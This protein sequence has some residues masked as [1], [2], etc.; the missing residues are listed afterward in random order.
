M[1]R[2]LPVLI[3]IV[4]SVMPLGG[5]SLAQDSDES[6]TALLV[7]ASDENGFEQVYRIDILTGN[8]EQLT[9][10]TNANV[11]AYDVSEN[12]LAY[13]SDNM[14][15]VRRPSGDTSYPLN[16]SQGFRVSVHI[17]PNE[18]ELSYADESGLYLLDLKSG[19]S[20]LIMEHKDFMDTNNPNGVGDGRYYY[21]AIFLD[22]TEYL[23]IGVGLWEASTTGF[24]NRRT[25]IFTELTQGWTDPDTL[26]EMFNLVLPLDN[27]QV[28]LHNFDGRGC[29]PCG[30]WLAPSLE[31]ITAYE[32]IFDNDVLALGTATDL[33][34]PGIPTMVQRPDGLVRLLFNYAAPDS[35][36]TFVTHNLVLELNFSNGVVSLLMDNFDNSMTYRNPAFSPS[37]DYLALIGNPAQGSYSE[38]GDVVVY[39]LNS[40]IPLNLALPFEVRSLRWAK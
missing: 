12:V 35:T 10:T 13:I 36:G 16:R 19:Q 1:K 20:S 14:L 30:L 23:Q 22:N 8:F 37:G 4:I 38:T 27:G 40:H 11:E 5:P 29:T 2:L 21:E 7:T 32:K 26:F 31:N 6:P 9:M 39:D 15:Y 3:L 34:A 33:L 28:L 24:Y 17:S 25:G 18:Q